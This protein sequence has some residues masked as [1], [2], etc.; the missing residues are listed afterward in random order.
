[1]R[2][3]VIREQAIKNIVKEELFFQYVLEEGIWSDVKSGV[4]KM[5]KGASKLFDSKKTLA[6]AKK[7]LEQFDSKP[8]ELV[9][10][11]KLIKKAQQETGETIEYDDTLKTAAALGKVSQ[12]DVEEALIS[13]L[14]GP[15]HD[16]AEELVSESKIRYNALSSSILKESNRLNKQRIDEVGVTSVLGIGLAAY[17]GTTMLVGLLAKLAKWL[18]AEKTYNLLHKAH[19]VLH[20]LEEK[21]ISVAIP[22]KISWYVYKAL[23]SRGIRFRDNAKQQLTYEQ[24][25]SGEGDVK[26]KIE[27][28]IYSTILIFLAYEGIKGA[29][30]AGTSLLGFTE[31]AASAVKTAEIGKA[32]AHLA[33]VIEI[34]AINVAKNV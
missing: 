29:I 15:V 19:H 2:R 27:K 1:M 25:K 28:I 10:M 11:M 24:F 13:D 7:A 18:G 3:S 32:A 9:D 12:S 20:H 22:T 17:G 8:D 16:K 5:V 21:A 34:G 6:S 4:K 33:D 30:H 26:K 23:H 31:G 14:K